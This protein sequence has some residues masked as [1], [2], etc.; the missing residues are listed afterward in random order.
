MKPI[1]M[2][3]LKGQYEKIKDEVNQGIQDCIDAT[4]FIN[5]PAVM[6]FQRDFEN[7]LQVKHVIPCANGTDALQIAMM[8][9]GLKLGDEVIVPAFTYV[10]T[11][12]VI[13]LLGLKPVMVDVD[14]DTFNIEIENLEKYVTA[15]T[16]AIVPVHLYG[17]SADMEKVMKFAEKHNLF[18]IEDNAQAI[19]ADYTFA[20]GTSKKT[21]T[22]GHIGCT[23]FFPSKNLGCYGDGGALM[24]NDDELAAKIRMIANH[25]QEKK[26]YHKVLG[27]NSRL[28]TI[29]AAVLKVKLKHLDK[30]SAAR[31]KMADY[32]DEHLKDI[33]AIEIPVRA[34]DSN[35]V[36]HQYTLKIKNGK[37]DDLQAYL[38]EKGIPSMIY[39]PLPL[40]RQEA[41][42]Q[43]VE[44]GFSL[45]VTED[46]CKEVLSLPVHTEFDQEVQD[47]IISE[48][49]SF[50][51]KN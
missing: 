8:A 29:Q 50:F 40:C 49:K 42:Q 26:Y 36:F 25:G 38:K 21:G 48:V 7:Y 2:V 23:S 31:N 45:P 10:A 3:D 28:D 19:G 11:A 27:C 1:Q 24:T 20:D 30:Y 15:N 33:D 46:L 17:Q 37:R 4:A 34:S 18:V 39:Y 32:Y 14:A 6:E 22:I 9:L 35:H 43:Y 47:Y 41:F 51:N 16:K 44:D 13:G 12:E 5:G